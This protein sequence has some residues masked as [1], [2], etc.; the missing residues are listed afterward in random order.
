MAQLLP[1]PNGTGHLTSERATGDDY[2]G[3][4][5]P[6][7]AVSSKRLLILTAIDLVVFAALVAVLRWSGYAG[8]Q[9]ALIPTLIVVIGSKFFGNKKDEDSAFG[10]HAAVQFTFKALA[11]SKMLTRWWQRTSRPTPTATALS[12]HWMRTGQRSSARTSNT[13]GRS[14]QI[15][16]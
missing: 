7:A 5:L 13:G 14:Y 16:Q 1:E 11:I 3:A 8:P 4:A 10:H 2:L 12:S 9:L 15:S 6:F